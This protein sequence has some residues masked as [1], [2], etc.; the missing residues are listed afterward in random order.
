MY[1]SARGTASLSRVGGASQQPSHCSRGH[2]IARWIKQ[3]ARG[4]RRAC[5]PVH[6]T[7]SKP[8]HRHLPVAPTVA[9][10]GGSGKW[11]VN[12]SIIAEE[13]ESSSSPLGVGAGAASSADRIHLAGKAECEE[14]ATRSFPTA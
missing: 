8:L 14:A 1:R 9:R 12:R 13:S 4:V 6:D 2:L 10:G 3:A 11:E 7:G 5:A